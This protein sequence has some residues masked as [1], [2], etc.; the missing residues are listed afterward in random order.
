MI[1]KMEI[2]DPTQPKVKEPDAIEMKNNR[3]MCPI[4]TNPKYKGKNICLDDLP[5]EERL[6]LLDANQLKYPSPIL[7]KCKRGYMIVPPDP[8]NEKIKQLEDKLK[9]LPEGKR[10][11][12]QQTTIDA[13]IS[14]ITAL[15]N[16]VNDLTSASMAVQDPSMRDATSTSAIS[17]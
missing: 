3:F 12:E 2:T 15:T 11:N 6:V 13:L 17:N 4:A 8:N 14:H 16:K 9:N 1:I 5:E 7:P 10:V